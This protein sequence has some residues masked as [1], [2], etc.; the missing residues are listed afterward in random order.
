MGGRFAI[1]LDFQDL[2]IRF[3]ILEA[4]EEDRDMAFRNCSKWNGNLTLCENTH[5]N[6]W[7]EMSRRFIKEYSW[8]ITIE[9][10]GV[11][12]FYTALI[13]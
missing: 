7:D 5:G 2:D 11:M 1:D 13:P 6:L 3:G 10:K 4:S 9:D 8:L 12:E